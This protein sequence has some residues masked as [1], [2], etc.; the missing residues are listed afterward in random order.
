MYEKG[1][2]LESLVCNDVAIVYD[3]HVQCFHVLL[4]HDVNVLL[5]D[6][7]I[8]ICCFAV[9]EGRQRAAGA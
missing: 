1:S 9:G 7:M 6:V 5:C 2:V 8:A 3:V 4:L